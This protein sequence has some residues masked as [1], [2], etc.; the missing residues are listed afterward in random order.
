MAGN[1]SLCRLDY[2]LAACKTLGIQRYLCGRTYS[3]RP[4]VKVEVEEHRVFSAIDAHF[5]VHLVPVLP[6]VGLGPQDALDE[7]AA[8]ATRGPPYC[9]SAQTARKQCSLLCVIF[10]L[11]AARQDKACL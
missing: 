2:E 6:L 8:S 5:S 10:M 1:Y 3:S 11:A 4:A 9:W 7:V